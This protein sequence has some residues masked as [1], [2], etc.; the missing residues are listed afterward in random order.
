MIILMK[1][2]KVTYFA[3]IWDD[4]LPVAD[5]GDEAADFVAKVAMIEDPTFKDVRV[6]AI[7][8]DSERRV[9]ETYCPDEARIG[10]F[11]GLPQSGFTDGFPVSSELSN[12][13]FFLTFC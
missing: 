6:V 3:G 7:L 5:V 4:A 13:I 8:E 10:L 1:V 2:L 11:G 12:C 9:D